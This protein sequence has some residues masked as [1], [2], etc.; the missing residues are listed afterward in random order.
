MPRRFDFYL[1][2]LHQGVCIDALKNQTPEEARQIL[3]QK[4]RYLY[5]LS[6]DDDLTDTGVDGVETI[7]DHALSYGGN[8]IGRIPNE[9]KFGNLAGE[10]HRDFMLLRIERFDTVEGTSE[11]AE[12]E[13]PQNGGEIPYYNYYLIALDII[14]DD[15]GGA[16]TCLDRF[17]GTLMEAKAYFKEYDF[18]DSSQ[19]DVYGAAAISS[20]FYPDK[21]I[22]EDPRFKHLQGAPFHKY[23][24]ARIRVPQIATNDPV[25]VNNDP[26]VGG[27]HLRISGKSKSRKSKS[28]KSKSRKSK[29]C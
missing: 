19:E 14:Y 4:W 25:N 17:K 1:F 15:S 21:Y 18:F 8:W 16:T 24:L 10:S 23:C 6:K 2:A 11:Y 7:V 27:K 13:D 22:P 3:R 28:R 12:N 26:I 5:W 20:S 9:P 29:C